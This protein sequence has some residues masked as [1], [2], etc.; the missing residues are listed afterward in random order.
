MF[1]KNNGYILINSNGGKKMVD[2]S[3]H[4]NYSDERKRLSLERGEP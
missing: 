4:D 1:D 3:P 2:T